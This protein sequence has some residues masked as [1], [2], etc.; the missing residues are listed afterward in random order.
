MEDG[1]CKA[2]GPHNKPSGC[3][4]RDN[5]AT[6]ALMFGKEV[7]L[8]TFDK[9]SASAVPMCSC[10]MALPS[11]TRWSKTDGAGDIG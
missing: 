3:G 7:K 2:K 6:S 1:V 4:N 8:Q 11:T 5:H 9:E 10:L